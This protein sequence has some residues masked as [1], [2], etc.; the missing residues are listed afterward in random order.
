[1]NPKIT[2]TATLLFLLGV[3][4]I[5]AAQSPERLS[6]DS[7]AVADDKECR[8]YGL[9]FGSRDYMDCRL[10]LRPASPT[11]IPE[12]KV[13]APPSLAPQPAPT[14]R[15]YQG[16][17]EPLMA[18]VNRAENAV[19]TI[20]EYN[21]KMDLLDDE[22]ERREA[23]ERSQA[24]FSGAENGNGR[25]NWG[26][27][28]AAGEAYSEIKKQQAHIVEARQRDKTLRDARLRQAEL[29][30]QTAHQAYQR[31]RGQYS[32]L[33]Q[34]QGN[35]ASPGGLGA[36]CNQHSDCGNSLI[37]NRSKCNHF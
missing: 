5:A 23:G 24:Y 19:S 15:Q 36:T 14:V 6:G 21:L 32:R 17:C 30:K 20:T 29:E 35:N 3:F 27:L 11:V 37:C 1:M 28:A 2:H 8:S 12:P 7:K 9:K 26:A 34:S 16:E 31:C 4:S 33:Q 18:R 10:R 13:V 25:G 22:A